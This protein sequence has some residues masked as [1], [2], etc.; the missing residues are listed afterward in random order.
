[1]EDI[2]PEN[3]QENT[4]TGVVFVA[5][6][7]DGGK[8]TELQISI[9]Y[10]PTG[11]FRTDRT[12]LSEAIIE[13]NPNL[14]ILETSVVSAED[15]GKWLSSFFLKL[16]LPDGKLAPIESVFHGCKKYKEGGPYTDIMEMKPSEAKKDPRIKNS[17]DFLGFEFCNHK[18]PKTPRTAFYDWLVCCA[19]FQSHNRGLLNEA[20]KHSAF[21]DVMFFPE[22]SLNS[23][24][25][26]L[27]RIVTLLNMELI[28]T[29]LISFDEFVKAG[30][31]ADVYKKFT[32][33]KDQ[34]IMKESDEIPLGP[35]ESHAE[36]APTSA[37]LKTEKEPPIKKSVPKKVVGPEN[38]EDDEAEFDF[39]LPDDLPESED[40]DF[41]D[42]DVSDS[43]K[44]KETKTSDAPAKT[45]DKSK[46]MPAAGGDVDG[47]EMSEKPAST[48]KGTRRAA[49]PKTVAEDSTGADSEPSATTKPKKTAARKKAVKTDSLSL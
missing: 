21:S 4:F 12:A 7:K 35:T 10:T 11:D 42:K 40:E 13:K 33:G 29:K 17:G 24:A 23:P 49:S 18:F 22:H 36:H 39:D 3:T 8:Y 25:A 45:A 14:D 46:A 34:D 30:E 41:K 15:K 5:G 44:V 28:G 9:P 43:Q 20:R 32:R 6:D 26:S 19:L 2:M 27:A 38:Y 1:M 48:S 37:P 47:A 31:K 16:R